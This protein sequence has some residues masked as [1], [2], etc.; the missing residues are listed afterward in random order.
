MVPPPHTYRD[1]FVLFQIYCRLDMGVFLTLGCYVGLL[2]PHSPGVEVSKSHTHM[3]RGSGDRS[4]SLDNYKEW[5]GMAEELKLNCRGKLYRSR[6]APIPADACATNATPTSC[7]M[8]T[9]ALLY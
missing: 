7:C 1:L 4:R 9:L 6:V 2:E 5:V 8:Q 3:C